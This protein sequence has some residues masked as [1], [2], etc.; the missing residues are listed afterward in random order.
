M[1]RAAPIGPSTMAKKRRLCRGHERALRIGEIFCVDAIALQLVMSVS[2][3][4]SARAIRNCEN[5]A[6]VN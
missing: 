6:A 5:S 2:I 4:S 3:S 1:T